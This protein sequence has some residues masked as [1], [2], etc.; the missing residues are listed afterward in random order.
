M[1]GESETLAFARRAR[2]LG[3][4]EYAW[5]EVRTMHTRYAVDVS[6]DTEIE[7]RCVATP[8]NAAR[9]TT[10]VVVSDDRFAS[11]REDRD[12]YPYIDIWRIG[13]PQEPKPATLSPPCDV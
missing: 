5:L 7:L 13:L 11:Y 6:A 9:V 3:R 12:G 1:H 4:R 2:A 8:L 10:L